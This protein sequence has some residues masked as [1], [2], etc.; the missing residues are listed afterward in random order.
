MTEK[1]SI[2]K[3]YELYLD[4][5]IGYQ[6]VRRTRKVCRAQHS[7]ITRS[8]T[9]CF[10]KRIR[11]LTLRQRL[12]LLLTGSI[13][14]RRWLSAWLA[15]CCASESSGPRGFLVGMRMST[16]GSVN[17]TK[18]RSCNNRLP[19]GKGEGVASAMCFSWLRTL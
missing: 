16:W 8:R 7:A 9:P 17:A 10:H 3:F 1:E 2:P 6:G 5:T 13:R 11:S 18:P 12:T 14:S 15:H 4:Q 19:E